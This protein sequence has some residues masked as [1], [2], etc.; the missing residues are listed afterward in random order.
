M[1]S[2]KKVRISQKSAGLGSIFTNEM[3]NL[4]RIIG[5]ARISPT[6]TLHLAKTSLIQESTADVFHCICVER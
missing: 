1:K 6:T 5:A 4:R 2:I 3:P